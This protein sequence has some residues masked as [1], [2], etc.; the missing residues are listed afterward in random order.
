MATLSPLDSVTRKVISPVI[1]RRGEGLPGPRPHSKE[2]AT[3][4]QD[5]GPVLTPEW[6]NLEQLTVQMP[7]PAAASASSFL[8]VLDKLLWVSLRPGAYLG[9]H[10]SCEELHATNPGWWAVRRPA[11]SCHDG[12]RKNPDWG[13][14]KAGRSRSKTSGRR[15]RLPKSALIHPRF[16]FC[17]IFPFP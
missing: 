11:P 5:P 15:V 3:P 8:I 2:V 1:V 7:S 14:Q 13:A 16:H 10:T 6:E 4:G 9:V 12:E 17:F